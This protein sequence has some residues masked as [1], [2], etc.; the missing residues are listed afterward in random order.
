MDNNSSAVPPTDNLETINNQTL[1][2]E[3]HRLLAKAAV[4]SH[5]KVNGS[6]QN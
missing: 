1:I 3:V 4:V 5:K 6:L 2:S